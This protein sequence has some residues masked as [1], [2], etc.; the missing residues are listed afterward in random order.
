MCY[1]S[2]SHNGVVYGKSLPCPL[3]FPL[4]VHFTAN[5]S[6]GQKLSPSFV[7]AEGRIYLYIYLFIYLFIYTTH[8]RSVHPLTANV[9]FHVLIS[10]RLKTTL[11]FVLGTFEN[12]PTRASSFAKGVS[13]QMAIY[14]IIIKTINLPELCSLVDSTA[15]F[16]GANL[17]RGPNLGYS[18]LN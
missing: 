6:D 15:G 8:N 9:G 16:R 5:I 1:R 2:D 7:N 3:H 4:T 14:I 10:C 13:F 11:T 18:Q 17:G 12:D